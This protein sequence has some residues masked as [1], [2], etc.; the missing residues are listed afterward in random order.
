MEEA[1]QLIAECGGDIQKALCRAIACLKQQSN[2]GKG[3][4]GGRESNSKFG[5][6]NG[7]ENRNF[8]S[9]Y[10]HRHMDDDRPPKSMGRA[11]MSSGGRGSRPMT[12]SGRG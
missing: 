9:S 3:N 5:F 8:T 6:N 4:E 12:G 1:E 11:H 7:K 10:S 2:D